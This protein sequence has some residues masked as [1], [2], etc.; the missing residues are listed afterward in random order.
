MDVFEK[1]IEIISP[2][3]DEN[4]QIEVTKAEEMLID[5]GFD[6]EEVGYTKEEDQDYIAHLF[7]DLDNG[8]GVVSVITL[9]NDEKVLVCKN[10]KIEEKEE[11]PVD[12]TP[13]APTPEPEK[14]I[15][16]DENECNEYNQ[17]VVSL[18]KTQGENGSILLSKIGSGVGKVPT[19]EKMIEYFK[20]FEQ[21]FLTDTLSVTLKGAK[22]APTPTPAPAAKA[23]PG[24]DVRTVSYYSL[25][26]FAH[27]ENYRAT[28][29]ELA[30]MAQP[31]GWFILPEDEENRYWLVEI[32]LRST[33]ALSV[34]EQIEGIASGLTIRPDSALFDTRFKTPEGKSII[35]CFTFNKKRNQ[36]NWQT[37]NFEKFAVE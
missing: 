18:I 9:P 36:S 17:K 16:I 10:V 22:G 13:S 12:E 28:V 8:Q 27:F 32:K 1:I 5:A 25:P 19:G 15:K 6:F 30:E 2:A 11:D 31:D 37:W 33:F 4:L 35:A 14:V 29:Q 7:E 26:H 23:Q 24:A 21:L 20:R 34:K 3:L